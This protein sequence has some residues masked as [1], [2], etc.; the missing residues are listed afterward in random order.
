MEHSLTRGGGLSSEQVRV[1]RV[2][3]QVRVGGVFLQQGHLT[4]PDWW[5]GT[6]G[7]VVGGRGGGGREG[8]REQ[9]GRRGWREWATWRMKG[10]RRGETRTEVMLDKTDD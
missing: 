7:G 5:G 4:F 8:R 6:R 10:Q 2:G 1:L 3:L 9:G